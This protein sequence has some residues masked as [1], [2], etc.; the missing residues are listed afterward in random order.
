MLCNDYLI[1]ALNWHFPRRY[2]DARLTVRSSEPV[3]SDV[4]N[5]VKEMIDNLCF[6]PS[7]DQKSFDLSTKIESGDLRIQSI[8]LHRET[9]HSVHDYKDILLHLVEVH[10]L[11]LSQP[12]TKVDYRASLP[13]VP[14][15]T[16]PGCKIWWEVSLSSMLAADTFKQN[17]ELELG[18]L[19]SWTPEEVC[20]NSVKDLSYVT[21]DLVQQI[22]A[23]GW[24]NKG[25]R[26]AS[27][28]KTS[29]KETPP[30]LLLYW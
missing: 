7:P 22:D 14:N 29:D 15:T 5:L 21:R 26:G 23:V 17:E 6:H 11:N 24:L 25:P 1:G 12:E 9:R 10:E 3:S 2:W 19:A 16:S 13:P 30:D 27:G 18:D 4:R 28:T 8:T 20:N